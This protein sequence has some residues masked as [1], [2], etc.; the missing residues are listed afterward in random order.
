MLAS[1]SIVLLRFAE[2]KSAWLLAGVFGVFLL[3]FLMKATK[4][5]MLGICLIFVFSLIH[6]GYF[7]IRRIPAVYTLG[8]IGMAAVIVLGYQF[9]QATGLLDRMLFLQ[10]L[11]G[12]F[13]GHYSVVVSL[14][15][16]KRLIL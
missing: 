1:A 6:N 5:A 8:L 11:H 15:S 7:K 9:I 4:V 10:Q 12:G 13:W 3:F 16:M 14:F 2:T